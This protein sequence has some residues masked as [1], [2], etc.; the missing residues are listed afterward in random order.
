[1]QHS[2]CLGFQGHHSRHPLPVPFQVHA[3]L[4]RTVFSEDK[5]NP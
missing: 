2:S 4:L 3:T 5:A 1:M